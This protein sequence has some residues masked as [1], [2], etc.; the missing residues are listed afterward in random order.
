MFAPYGRLREVLH[1]A[2]KQ[3]LMHVRYASAAALESPEFARRLRIVLEDVRRH[4]REVRPD[5]LDPHR[6]AAGHADRRAR[7]CSAPTCARSRRDDVRGVLESELGEPVEPGVRVVRVRT[8]RGGLDR[9][10]PP[11]RAPRRHPR[12]REGP[13]TRVSSDIVRRDASVLRLTARQLERRVEAARRVGVRALAEELI[14]GIEEELD[15][16]REAARRDA[17]AREPGRRRRHRDPRGALR[18]LHAP[19]PRDGRGAS[20]D[21]SATASAVDATVDESGVGRP[22]LAHNLLASFLGQILTDGQ[23]HADPHPGNVLVDR[24]G[25]ALAPRLRVGRPPR[26][27]RARGP[28]GP[29][30]RLRDERPG[31]A[32]PRRTPPRRRRH[33]R[34]PALARD[35]PQPDAGRASRPAAAS[36]R[37]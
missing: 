34:R 10:D 2:R 14:A 4:V 31:P 17:A 32:G 3:N 1:Y 23:Y 20:R 28:P 21:R 8:A 15:Y 27:A 33:H 11:R 16:L 24:A 35:R 29:R 5:R 19:H 6:H 36:T 9:P 37:S 25:V 13:A 22:V 7:R 30:A 18:P 12:R 26:P